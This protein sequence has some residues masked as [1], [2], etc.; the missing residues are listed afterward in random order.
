MTLVSIKRL[1][2]ASVAASA[3]R[4]HTGLER[5]GKEAPAVERGKA[6]HQRLIPREVRLG[7]SLVMMPA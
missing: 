5:G 6:H 1:S 2:T 7:L 4:G 3:A